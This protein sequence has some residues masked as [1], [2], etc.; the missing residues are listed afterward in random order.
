MRAPKQFAIVE[1]S[2]IASKKIKVEI[3]QGK[4][5]APAQV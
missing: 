1:G 5:G 3:I 4:R 2:L